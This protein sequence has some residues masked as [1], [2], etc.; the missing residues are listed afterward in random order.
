MNEV[1]NIDENGIGIQGYDPVSYFDGT[2]QQGDRSIA[3]E[4][5]GV[6]YHFKSR[7]NRGKFA[8]DPR[9]YL[10]LYGGYCAT[11]MAGNMLVPIDPGNFRIE[12]ERLLLFYDGEMGN[13]KPAWE[14][15]PAGMFTQ[16]ESNWQAADFDPM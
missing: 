11:G 2:P 9:A 15:D 8:V 4:Y 7:E 1:Q 5:K 13:T 14:K 12:N 10:P 6:R 3:A 16:A